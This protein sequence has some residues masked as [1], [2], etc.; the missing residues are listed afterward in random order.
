MRQ[1]GWVEVFPSPYGPLLNNDWAPLQA[2][3]RLGV[4]YV[5][6]AQGMLLQLIWLLYSG[7]CCGSTASGWLADDMLKSEWASKR[8]KN[9]NKINT[10]SS[11]QGFSCFPPFRCLPVSL[12]LPVGTTVPIYLSAWLPLYLNCIVPSTRGH[13]HEDKRTFTRIV[14]PVPCRNEIKNFLF[15]KVQVN[16]IVATMASTTLVVILLHPLHLFYHHHHHNHYNNHDPGY[17]FSCESI[18]LMLCGVK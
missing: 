9:P 3:R 2:T 15:S 13:C 12:T 10:L 6:R 11:K 5:Y 1:V 17:Y 14:T 16:L 7:N 18:C 4:K 8:G